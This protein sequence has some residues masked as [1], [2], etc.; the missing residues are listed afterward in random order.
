[1]VDERK[2]KKMDG[3]IYTVSDAVNALISALKESA[4]AFDYGSFTFKYHIDIGMLVKL[5]I[6]EVPDF[7]VGSNWLNEL[8]GHDWLVNSIEEI[9]NK[10]GVVFLLEE[11][12]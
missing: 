9:E 4:Y 12:I 2:K 5:K 3:T 7:P 8:S 6:G 1:M 11:E 10:F